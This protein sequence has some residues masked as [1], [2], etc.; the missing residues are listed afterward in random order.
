MTLNNEGEEGFVGVLPKV[1]IKG[2]L[3][4]D[5]PA[6]AIALPTTVCCPLGKPDKS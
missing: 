3:S 4:F 2:T 1:K 5:V 6:M